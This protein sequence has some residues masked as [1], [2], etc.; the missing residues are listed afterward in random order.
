MAVVTG[1][2]SDAD[3]AAESSP[4]VT[5]EKRPHRAV[6]LVLVLLVAVASFVVVPSLPAEWRSL[7]HFTSIG[8]GGPGPADGVHE[9][10]VTVAK[11]SRGPLV[12]DWRCSGLFQA[13]D[14]MSDEY[15]PVANVT[16]VNDAHLRSRGSFVD[17]KLTSGSHQAYLWGG[18]EQVRVLA[19]WAGVLLFVMAGLVT[20]PR[21]LRRFRVLALVP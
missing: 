10:F 9:G 19:F 13:N 2:G 14:P 16:V 15:P 4:D 21:R 12:F 1:V 18:L 3:A 17:V 20:A 7:S 8:S 6:A 11:C 5:Q